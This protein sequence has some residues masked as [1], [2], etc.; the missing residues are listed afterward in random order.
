[1]STELKR[2]LLLVVL[3]IISIITGISPWINATYKLSDFLGQIYFWDWCWI[4]ASCCAILAIVKVLP[5][6]Q[7]RLNLTIVVVSISMI[8]LISALSYGVFKWAI[9]TLVMN[10]PY[11]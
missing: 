4:L 1:M 8:T 10:M 2:I 3:M 5:L 11:G 9:G 7:T 6:K